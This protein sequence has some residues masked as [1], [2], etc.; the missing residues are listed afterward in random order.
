MKCPVRSFSTLLATNGC[1]LT[2][3]FEVFK[4]NPSCGVFCLANDLFGNLVVDVLLESGLL[5][6]QLAQTTAGGLRANGL[7]LVSAFLE[8]LSGSFDLVTSIVV[9]VAGGRY[10]DYTHI[11]AKKVVGVVSGLLVNVA[12]LV[13]VELTIAIDQISLTLTI[14]Q[15]SKLLLASDKL[16]LLSAFDC[17][18]GHNGLLKFPRENTVIVSNR[19]KWSKLSLGFLVKLV[20]VCHLR[21]RANGN[22]GSQLELLTHGIVAGVMQVV[23][24]EALAIPSDFTDEVCGGV[25][26][27]QRLTQAGKLQSMRLEFHLCNQFHKDK[28]SIYSFNRQVWNAP[29]T[30][31]AEAAKAGVFL[32]ALEGTGFPILKGKYL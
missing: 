14:L 6:R 30:L 17:P 3:A 1:P 9:S 26:F 4:G 25:G 22:L 12:S 20:R 23:L 13:K 28:Y 32:P 18:D 24:L 5:A 15:H 27:F 16:D 19:A 21:N 31:L 29:L 10:V 2:D 8:P 11:N 7:K